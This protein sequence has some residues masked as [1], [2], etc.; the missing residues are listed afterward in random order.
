[1]PHRQRFGIVATVASLSAVLLGGCSSTTAPTP[2]PS[3]TTTAIQ[4]SAASS[5][6][7]DP[8]ANWTPL[9]SQTGAI[10]LRYYPRWSAAK[11]EPGA[12]YAWGTAVGPTT[13]IYISSAPSASTECPPENESPEILIESTP[14]SAT[15][16]ATPG[17]GACGANTPITSQVTVHGVRGQ[18]QLI[19]YGTYSGCIG[20]PIVAEDRYTFTTDG[21]L[22]TLNYAY[23]QDD[24][25]DLTSDF[26]LMVQDTVTFSA[27]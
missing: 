23:R 6:T 20:I 26:D 11:C 10:S 12:H 9:S 25:H 19:T 21:R 24:A 8:T 1:M 3:S 17:V 16:Q 27:S 5:P 15:P 13:T 18:R 22:Y 14:T 7:F 2:S 4:S